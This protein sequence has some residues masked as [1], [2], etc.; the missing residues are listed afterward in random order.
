MVFWLGG[1][2]LGGL[3]SF[4]FSVGVALWCW[5]LGILDWLGLTLYLR[6]GLERVGRS[7]DVFWCVGFF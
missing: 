7:V 3:W 4:G 2:I 1:W 6:F 5:G